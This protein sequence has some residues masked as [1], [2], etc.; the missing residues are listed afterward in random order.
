MS[1]PT[2]I[3]GTVPFSVPAA[4]KP[5]YTW[6]K[7]F[8]DLNSGV[9]PLILLH[10]GPGCTSDYLICFQEFNAKYNIPVILYDQIGNGRSTHLPE[11]LDDEEFWVE[12]LFHDQLRSLVSSL[13]LDKEEKGYYILGQSWGGMMGSTFISTRPKGLQKGVLSNSPASLDLWLEAANAYLNEMPEELRSVLEKA[14][15]TGVYEGE[16]YEN[17]STEFMKRHSCTVEWPEEFLEVMR[18]MKE[19]PTVDMTMNGPSQFVAKATGSYSNWSAIEAV[20]NINVPMLVINGVNEC[21]TDKA[22]KPFLD[23]IKDVKWV[24]L[25]NSTHAPM[26]EEKEKYFEVIAEFLLGKTSS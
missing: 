18:W 8:G 12:S 5:C 6:Y 11:K 26:Y 23:G 3:E 15:E 24:K 14:E 10:G 22:I 13:G 9:T 21:A 7:I 2:I 20:K 17:A 1:T 25:Q 4:N 16:E 19:D